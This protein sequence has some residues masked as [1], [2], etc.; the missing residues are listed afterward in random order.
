MPTLEQARAQLAHRHVAGVQ[1]GCSP[2]EQKKYGSMIHTM[3][4]LLRSAGLSQALHF[5]AARSDEHQ[6]L[7]VDHFAEQL[8]RIDDGIRSPEALLERVRTA[9]LPR[10][11]RLH[12][13]ALA[14]ADWY[15]RMVQGVL[16]VEA[17]DD[18]GDS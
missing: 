5:V 6:R 16:K 10:Y 1:Q 18:D 12:S 13:E 2:K 3:P 9:P 7:V 8:R 11:L 14:C 4:A 15:R 17:G